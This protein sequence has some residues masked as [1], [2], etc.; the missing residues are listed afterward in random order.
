M[1]K[2]RPPKKALAILLLAIVF[3]LAALVAI[4]RPRPRI[5]PWP[6]GEGCWWWAWCSWWRRVAWPEVMPLSPHRP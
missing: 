1:E 4:Y 3:L 2:A 5:G 6:T